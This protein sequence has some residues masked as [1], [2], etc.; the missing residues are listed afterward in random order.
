MARSVRAARSAGPGSTALPLEWTMYPKG[1]ARARSG[2]PREVRAAAEIVPREPGAGRSAPSARTTSNWRST[3]P[4]RPAAAVPG[5][6]SLRELRWARSTTMMPALVTTRPSMSSSPTGSPRTM[7]PVRMP[8]TGHGQVAD[9]R[10][11]G[12][13]DPHDRLAGP[14]G[15]GRGQRTAVEDDEECAQVPVDRRPLVALQDA[16]PG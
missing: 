12:T 3:A 8:A 11:R 9:A 1:I 2:C 16:R 7:T 5:E 13:D 4:L 6:C 15:E 14:E 10:G